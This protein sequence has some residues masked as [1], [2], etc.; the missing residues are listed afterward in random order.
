M[1]K[2][3]FRLSA[4]ALLSGLLLL[5]PAGSWFP[6]IQFRYIHI[7]LG[8]LLLVLFLRIVSTHAP[9]ELGNPFKRGVKKWNGFKYA[10]YLLIA[11]LSGLFMLQNW[12]TL[13]WTIY[14]HLFFG[15][16]CVLVGWKHTR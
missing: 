3:T 1:P 4:L 9:T 10:F 6:W 15:A 16:W 12:V 7:G 2:T 5:I 8:L 14:V 13:T 11:I